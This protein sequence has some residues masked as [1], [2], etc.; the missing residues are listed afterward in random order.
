MLIKYWPAETK[1]PFMRYRY[2]G[3]ALSLLVIAASIFLLATRGLNLG[4]DFAGGS[5]IELK[6]TETVTV[7]E[8]RSR[9]P[10]NLTVNSATN[11]RGEAN[12]NRLCSET[13]FMSFPKK[14]RRARPLRFPTSSL[15]MP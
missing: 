3:V 5:V 2:I 15:L 13:R 11:G 7:P 4:V 10:G 8:V 12:W 9:I 14:R 6:E 1:I